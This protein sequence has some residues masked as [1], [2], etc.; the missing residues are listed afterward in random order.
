MIKSRFKDIL[1][2]GEKPFYITF[3]GDK[4]N[5]LLLDYGWDVAEFKD[6]K[7]IPLDEPRLLSS[8]EWK[9]V[10]RKEIDEITKGVLPDVDPNDLELP[11]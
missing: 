4:E 3:D 6:G 7:W 11:Q 2:K 1:P 9:D 10:S 8:W 5:L